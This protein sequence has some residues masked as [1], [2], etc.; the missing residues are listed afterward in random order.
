LSKKEQLMTKKDMASAIA[1]KSGI[2][3]LQALEIIHRVFDSIIDT[4]VQE[5]RIELRNFGVFKV[6][7][8]KPRRARNPLTGEEVWVPEKLVT[9]FKASQELQERL[10]QLQMVP[11]QDKRGTAGTGGPRA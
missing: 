1:G 7:R 6:K 8:R 3:K 9:S 11:S 5:G 10:N 4:L 2:P